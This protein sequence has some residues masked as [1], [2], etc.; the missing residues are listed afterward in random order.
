M[1]KVLRGCIMERFR[2]WPIVGTDTNFDH[3]CLILNCN[4]KSL[5]DP[6]KKLHEIFPLRKYISLLSFI[7]QASMY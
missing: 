5:V 2:D 6:F 4:T 7:P 3:C 1:K